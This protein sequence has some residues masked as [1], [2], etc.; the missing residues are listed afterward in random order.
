MALGVA[1][2]FADGAGGER[3]DVL[4]RRRIGSRRRHHDAVLHRAVVRQRLDHL[5]DRR[6]LLA[7]GAVDANHVAALLIDDRVEHDGGLAGLA[8]AD[9]QLALAA[10]D[11]NH[12]VDGL[13]AGLQR[14]AH[15]LPVDDAR[16]DTLE[17]VAL[18]GLDRALCRRSACPSGIHHAPDQRLAHRHG[19]DPVRAL[20][21]VAFRIS[22]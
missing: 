19:H 16:R 17:R 8:V 7:D 18:V 22:V 5:R 20:H 15:R 11:R 10:A 12:R 3:R 6:A 1:E 2:V 14:L 21:R 4:H 13:D 9:D